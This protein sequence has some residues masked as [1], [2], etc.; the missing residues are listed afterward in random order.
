M[1]ERICSVPTCSKLADTPG[2][3]R[4]LCVSH[5]SQLQRAGAFKRAR[6]E[7]CRVDNCESPADRPVLGYCNR[8]YKKLQRH[9]DPTAGRPS[10]TPEERFW[11]MAIPGDSPDDCWGW[12]GKLHH[13]G[14]A[15]L[16]V[17]GAQRPAHRF[18]Y[19]MVHGP[20]PPELHIDHLCRNR[21]CTNPAHL[22]AVP[23]RVNILRGIGRGALNAIKT[24]CPQGHPYDEMNTYTL[25]SRPNARYCRACATQRKLERRARQRAAGERVT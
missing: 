10:G 20:V 1:V 19:E 16:A 21:G 12:R 18:S 17:D 14:Y 13:L 24:H 9:G 3:A 25:P 15:H 2:A 5:Y 6:F 23:P 4:G 8:H 11:Q 7:I 22:E